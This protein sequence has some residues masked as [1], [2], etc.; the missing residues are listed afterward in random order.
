[1]G[2]RG[3]QASLNNAEDEKFPVRFVQVCVQVSFTTIRSFTRIQW[4]EGAEK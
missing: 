4:F 3:E 2:I 1:M